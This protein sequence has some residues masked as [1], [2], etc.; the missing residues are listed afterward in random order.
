MSRYRLTAVFLFVVMF[1]PVRADEGMWIPLLLEQT[2][3]RQMKEL[4]LKLSPEDIYSINHASLKDA[5]VLFGGGCSGVVVSAQGLLFTNYHCGYGQVQSHSSL[6]HDYLTDGF[7]AQS[8]GDELPN[9]GLTATFLER[10]EDVTA[11]VLQRI[12][13]GMTERQRNDSIAAAVAR[14]V[15]ARQPAKHHRV[16]VKPLFGG[17]QY[18]MYVYEIFSDVRLVGAP[19][20]AIGKF[21]GDTDNW[22]WPRHTGDFSIFRIYADKNNQPAAYSPDNVPYQPRKYAPVSIAGIREGDFTMVY[23]YPAATDEFI[24]SYEL[25]YLIRQ[26]Y[27]LRVAL[28]TERLEIMERYMQADAATRIQY[29]AKHAG[30]SNAW[31][32]WQGVI[33]GVQRADGVK[34]KI[35]RETA[36]SQQIADNP[37]WSRDYGLLLEKMKNNVEAAA[38]LQQASACYA[39]SITSIELVKFAGSLLTDIPPPNQDLLKK[40]SGFYKDFSLAVDKDIFVAMMK[41]Y[42]A[43][44]PEAYHF[45]EMKAQLKRHKGSV[46]KWADEVYAKSVFRSYQALEKVLANPKSANKLIQKEPMIAIYLSGQAML[47]ERV[48]PSL[49]RLSQEHDSLSRVYIAAQLQADK[50]RIFYPNA[51]HTM[52]IS[53][54]QTVGYSPSDAVTYQPFTTLEGIMEKDNPDIYDYRVPQALKQA[55]EQKNFGQYAAN[56]MVP[57]CFIA[58][59]HTSGGN[60]GSPVF[61]G[62]GELIGLNFDR[63]WEGTMSDV[64]YDAEQ[65]RNIIAD[66]RYIL[67]IVDKV[68]GAQRIVGEMEVRE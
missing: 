16:D 51:N 5:V 62:N 52:R 33:H 8:A 19:P 22:I 13:S 36:F 39:E 48:Y 50:E 58:S 28:R 31:K 6:E 65:C 53:F 11:E 32:K 15:K 41:A 37:Q 63:N 35:A 24:T 21:G 9:P 7:W 67:F 57:V 2:R 44:I 46:E 66:I 49:R 55:A 27:P 12:T 30:V 23:G 68:Y 10:M 17:N 3:Y 4:G 20:T 47:N 54:G 18:F 56:G 29:A 59:N 45:E 60:S 64:V 14:I 38:L 25:D 1:S 40:A 42:L 34:Q 61:N 26:N 43:N